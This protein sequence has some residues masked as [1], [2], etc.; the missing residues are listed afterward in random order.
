[1]TRR[2]LSSLICAA[3]GASLLAQCRDRT[4]SETTSPTTPP[5][6]TGESAADQ[7]A[8]QEEIQALACDQLGDV[9]A[10]FTDPGFVDGNRVG[11]YVVFEGA[12]P[13]DKFLK[14]WWDY[15]NLPG[16]VQR[17]DTEAVD[18]RRR[19]DSSFDVYALVEHE[20]A[21]RRNTE[22]TVRV[23]LVLEGTTRG[24]ARNRTTVV[25][26]G[27]DTVLSRVV[28]GTAPPNV[29]AIDFPVVDTSNV[30]SA[31]VTV[32]VTATGSSTAA[33]MQVGLQRR[34][35][36][37]KWRS[38]AVIFSADGVPHTFQFSAN[39]RGFNPDGFAI[40]FRGVKS[41]EYRLQIEFVPR[42]E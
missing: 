27:G 35:A 25:G 4:P 15:T 26:P 16:S 22:V 20:Y 18:T 5:V 19:S 41:A 36:C 3:L 39:V 33:Q 21:F 10:R 2:S 37:C 17:V 11:L 12:P 23:E 32:T 1:M 29:T 9:R 38:P 30:E 8:S 7:P 13:G 24:C 42:R 40:G 14:I 6:A 28:N 31:D 34:G